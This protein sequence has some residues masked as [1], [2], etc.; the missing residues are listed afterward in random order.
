MRKIV[1]L[2]LSDHAVQNNTKMFPCTYIWEYFL[3]RG[4]AFLWKL[5][6]NLPQFIQFS[7]ILDC[8]D[9]HFSL[10]LPALLADHTM[11]EEPLTSQKATPVKVTSLV[12]CPHPMSLPYIPTCLIRLHDL[13]EHTLWSVGCTPYSVLCTA[14]VVGCNIF[15]CGTSSGSD[16]VSTC[17]CMYIPHFLKNTRCSQ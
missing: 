7:V 2:Q 12:T 6:S 16:V 4:N 8:Q 14:A 5:Y 15:S 13:K 10:V 9:Q 1:L 3:D 11:L 17:V